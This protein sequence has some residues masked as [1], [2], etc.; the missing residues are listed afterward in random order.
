[1]DKILPKPKEESSEDKPDGGTS[2]GVVEIEGDGEDAEQ[3]ELERL[4]LSDERIKDI[5]RIRTK[6]LLRRSRARSELDGWANLQGAEEDY[7]ELMK[8]GN[9]PPGD[10]KVV[11]NALRSLPA[12]INQAKDNEM[13]E[14]MGKLKDVSCFLRMIY[15]PPPPLAGLILI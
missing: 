14:M 1:M 3:A 5:L 7:K 11:R 15:I 8:M 9:L 6:A 4:K 13:A 2:G 10:E 12:R